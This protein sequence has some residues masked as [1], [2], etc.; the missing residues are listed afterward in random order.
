MANNISPRYRIEISVSS[1]EYTPN[2]VVNKVVRFF[3]ARSNVRML[4]RPAAP[5]WICIRARRRR[6]QIASRLNIDSVTYTLER[7]G[8]ANNPA[9]SVIAYDVLDRDNFEERAIDYSIYRTVFWSSDN[10]PLT[11]FERRDLR[12]YVASGTALSKKNLAIAG[13]NYPRQHVG[14]DVINDQASS[15]L[16]CA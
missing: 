15:S 16:C 7:I 8:Y 10:N 13:Q 12:A 6:N 5:L 1:D 4:A 9:G 11:R 14:M 2:N 3:V